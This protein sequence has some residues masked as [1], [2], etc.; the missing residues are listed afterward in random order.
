MIHHVRKPLFQVNEDKKWQKV[1]LDIGYSATNKNIGAILKAHYE[2]ILYP[3][4]VFEREEKKKAQQALK[5][6]IVSHIVPNVSPCF[7]L[8]IR[9]ITLFIGFF[10]QKDEDPEASLETGE[11][12]KEYKP[13]NIQGRMGMRVPAD[14]DKAGRRSK[15]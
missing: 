3:L 13:H 15:R 12:E 7:C 10:V 2:R 5:E 1:A 4:E 6:E 11:E 14:K 8:L 9:V